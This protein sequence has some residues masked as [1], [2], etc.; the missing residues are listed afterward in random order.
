MKYKVGDKV[1]LKSTE[2][3][4]KLGSWTEECAQEC[5]GK[6]Y[7]I[8][9]IGLGNYWSDNVAFDEDSIECLINEDTSYTLDELQ[10]KVDEFKEYLAEVNKRNQCSIDVWF[11]THDS[12][13][14]TEVKVY[15]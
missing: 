4:I 8:D 10:S 5:G 7:R 3:L 15:K 6:S 1:R 13:I 2:E 14:A 9:F 12:G 11:D